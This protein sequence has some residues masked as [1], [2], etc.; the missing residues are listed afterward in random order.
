[1]GNEP[2]I[3]RTQRSVFMNSCL[4]FGYLEKRSVLLGGQTPFID[5]VVAM[6]KI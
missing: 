4:D 1:V 3:G 2:Y 5:A 6:L